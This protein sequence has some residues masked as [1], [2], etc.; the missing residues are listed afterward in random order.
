MWHLEWE[1]HNGEKNMKMPFFGR[2]SQ[3]RWS[4][5][6]VYVMWNN[7]ASSNKKTGSDIQII[8]LLV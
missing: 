5:N 6:M 1:Q 7:T 3:A 8:A 2:G 4:G